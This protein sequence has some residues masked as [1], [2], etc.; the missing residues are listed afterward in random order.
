M[1]GSLPG[2]AIFNYVYASINEVILGKRKLSAHILFLSK[3]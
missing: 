3:H 1:Y 2:L